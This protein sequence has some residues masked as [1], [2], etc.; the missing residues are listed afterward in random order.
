[1]MELVIKRGDT[2]DHFSAFELI[3]EDGALLDPTDWTP[4]SQVLFGDGTRAT[5]TV[6]KIGDGTLRLR[7]DT[8][9]W[10]TGRAYID[11]QFTGPGGHVVSSETIFVKVLQDVTLV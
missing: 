2:L 8:T 5:L 9:S 4:T 11:V 6:T 1:M 10:A 7:G 3:A